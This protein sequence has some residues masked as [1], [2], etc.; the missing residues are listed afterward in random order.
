MFADQKCI[1]TQNDGLLASANVG[2]EQDGICCQAKIPRLSQIRRQARSKSH[3]LVQDNNGEYTDD[4]FQGR[5]PRL[6][7]IRR[8]ARSRHL[9]SKHL[10]LRSIQ[11]LSYFLYAADTILLTGC[12]QKQVSRIL[13]EFLLHKVKQ[14]TPIK[15]VMCY[16]IYCNVTFL[17]S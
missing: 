15:R 16:F 3:F 7:Q 8:L 4:H 10:K 2:A 13:E 1:G 5:R 12:D 14:V 6:S 11:Y 17:C 9:Q